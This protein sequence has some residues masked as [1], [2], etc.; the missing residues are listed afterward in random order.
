M[1]GVYGTPY[2]TNWISLT[3]LEVKTL[4]CQTELAQ[5]GCVLTK[6]NCRLN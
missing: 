4:C 1:S 5:K 2:R 6:S 3:E